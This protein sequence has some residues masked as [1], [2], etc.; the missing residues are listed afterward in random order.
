MFNIIHVHNAQ[1]QLSINMQ[2]LNKMLNQVF[3]LG[4]YFCRIHNVWWFSLFIHL[5]AQLIKIHTVN[6]PST[7]CKMY[8]ATQKS[9]CVD[10]EIK[11]ISW[12]KQYLL[13]IT[14]T[15]HLVCRLVSLHPYPDIVCH[16]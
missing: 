13:E 3:H 14:S 8:T 15:T 4:V 5:M 12:H 10:N 9:S 1:K 16:T 2:S 7:M 6:N 11:N